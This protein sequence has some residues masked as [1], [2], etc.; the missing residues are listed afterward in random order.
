MGGHDGDIIVGILGQW[1]SGKSSAARTLVDHLGGEGKVTFITDRALL[2]QQTIN[3]V[4]ETADPKVKSSQEDDGRKRLDGKLATVFLRPGEDLE[5]VDLNN[6]LFDLHQDVYDKVPPGTPNWL[7]A[8]RL[9]LGADV[10]DKSG[11]G[12]PIVIEAGFGTNKEPR[13]KNPFTHTLSDLFTRLEEAG[14]EP[15]LVRWIIVE[16]DFKR[17]LARNDARPDSVPSLEFNRFA[18][19]GGDLDPD[20][21]RSLEERGIVIKRVPNNH[22]DIE[23]FRRDII[24]AFDELFAR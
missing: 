6:M 4:L 16:A 9:Q 11:E 12:K 13:G 23:K 15:G 7:D 10:L 22:D 2:S 24:T 5:S 20:E 3:H 19:E 21:Q 14:V 8:V 17:R 1:A 18:A